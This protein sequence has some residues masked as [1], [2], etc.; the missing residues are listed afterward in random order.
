MYTLEEFYKSR[1]WSK[2]LYT[3]KNDRTNDD[4]NIVCDYCGKEILKKYDC[5]GHHKIELTDENVNDYNISLNPNN[6]ILVHHRCHNYI[7]HKF[8][9]RSRKIYL[10][11]GAPLSGKTSFVK[12][13][14]CDGDIVVDIDSIWECISGKERYIKPHSLKPFVFQIRDLII[15]GIKHRLGRWKTAYIIGGYPLKSERDLLCKMIGA[16][17]VF[18]DTSKEECIRRLEDNDEGR[19]KDEWMQAIND[20]FDLYT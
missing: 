17:E 7:H 18:I 13:N 11:Y 2:L 3:I 1:E 5:I 9:Y 12:D 4:G 8:E 15:D 10:V 19:D 6:I 20:W 16:E 14:M